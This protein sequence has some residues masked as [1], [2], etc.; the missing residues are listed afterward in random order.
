MAQVLLPCFLPSWPA[1]RAKIEAIERCS[2]VP[3]LVQ[4]M[5]EIH[6]ISK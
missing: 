2:T 6:E 1:V 4:L 5:T 3:E